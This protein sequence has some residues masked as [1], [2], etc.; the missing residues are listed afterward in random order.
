MPVELSTAE[1]FIYQCKFKKAQ[2]IIESFENN[3]L[4]PEKDQ[5]LGLLLK[6]KLYCYKGHYK[7]AIEIGEIAYQLSLKLDCRFESIEALLIKTRI[8]Y[9]GKTEDAFNLVTKIEEIEKTIKPKSSTRLFRQKVDLLLIKSIIYIDRGD[10]NQALDLTKQC[11]ILQEEQSDPLDLSRTYHHMGLILLYKGDSNLGL[12]YALKSLE[13]QKSLNNNVGI[14]ESLY[15]VGMSY[16]TTGD[17]DRALKLIKQGLMIDEISTLT[18]LESLD[19]LAIIYVNKGELDRALRYRN[20][21]TK[22]AEKGEFNEQVIINTYGIGL[23]YRSKGDINQ[24]LFYL[25][26]S[27]ELSEKHSS[28]Y[29]IQISLFN[30]IRTHLD[31]N[32]LDTAK[33]Y[34]AQLEKLSKKLDSKIFINLFTVAKALVLK[35]SGRIRHRTEAELLLRKITER[36]FDSPTIYYCSLV[37]F[38]E[39]LLEELYLTNNVEVINELNPLINKMFDIAEKQNAYPWLAEI[40]LL[41]AKLA[42]IQLDFDKA[43]QLLTQAQRIAELHGLNLLAS[44]ISNEHD[45]LLNQMNL[46]SNLKNLN[47]PMSDRIELASFDGVVDRMQGKQALEI[48]TLIPEVPVLLLIIGEGGFLLFS[49][50]FGRDFEI[51]EDL[52]GGF[53]TAINDF[54]GEIFSKGLDRAKFGDYLLLMKRINVFSVYYVYIG[55]SYLAKQRLSKFTERIQTTKSIWDSLLNFYETNRIVELK[56]IPS[57]E[58][59]INEVFFG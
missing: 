44:K 32:S 22:L 29:G 17:L 45:N 56:D 23:I 1:R 8:A 55:Q 19:L 54:S 30:L 11:L 4:H 33:Q 58:A 16:Y 43:K 57:L 24:A 34:L 37:N 42:L 51:E 35:K 5:L 40:K 10:L 39:L 49:A 27:L 25:K 36:D 15:L 41:Q 13:L 31:E 12:K 48:P 46:W 38:C 59:V 6:G 53:L 14:A 52:I 2:K 7:L 9:L 21:I 20:K 3:G 26:K 18:K 50:Q 28:F 47:A